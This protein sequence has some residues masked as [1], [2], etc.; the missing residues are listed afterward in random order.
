MVQR[1]PDAERHVDAHLDP[2][3]DPVWTGRPDP[4]RLFS[5]V[6]FLMM[7]LSALM[8]ALAVGGFFGILFGAPDP[9]GIDRGPDAA[10]IVGSVLFLLSFGGFAFFLAVGR[11]QLKRA[12]K[13]RTY[14]GLTEHRAVLVY[15][16]R[17][18]HRVR[19]ALL[20]ESELDI[21]RRRDG[22]GTITFRPLHGSRTW[23]ATTDPFYA[24]ASQ[25][26]PVAFWDLINVDSAAAKIRELRSRRRT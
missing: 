16:G 23:A 4:K 25:N 9:P 17:W 18:V 1:D 24:M 7:P 21:R 8:V 12:V 15:D 10:S 3:E 11:F 19:E 6:D 20:S 22:S 26:G 2:D 14:Y 5:P 13:R